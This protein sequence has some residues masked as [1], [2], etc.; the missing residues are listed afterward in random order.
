LLNH[1]TQPKWASGRNDLP[2]LRNA[3]WGS[4]KSLSA[5]DVIT[6]YCSEWDQSMSAIKD[7]TLMLEV[8]MDTKNSRTGDGE[9]FSMHGRL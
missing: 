6:G 2:S 4:P 5:G 9:N 7:E 3:P 8:R 1:V